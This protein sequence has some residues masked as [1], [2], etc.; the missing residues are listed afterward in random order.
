[1]QAIGFFAAVLGKTGDAQADARL[2]ELEVRCIVWGRLH[3]VWG[4]QAV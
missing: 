2:P 3:G 4:A 1:V